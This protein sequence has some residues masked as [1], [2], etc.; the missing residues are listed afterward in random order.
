MAI[1][2]R[3]VSTINRLVVHCSMSSFG[4][5]EIIDQWHKERG[6]DKIGYH[7]VIGNGFKLKHGDY[8]PNLDG[9]IET[10]RSL[11]QVGAHVK[12]FN[13]DS[14]GV[15]LVG[16]RLFTARQTLQALPEL[17]K[18][19][20]NFLGRFLV[21]DLHS[22]LDDHKYCPGFDAAALAVIKGMVRP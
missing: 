15:C 8:D 3:D 10:G 9:K 17:I 7:Y 19:V 13:R 14:I 18:K 2:T 11:G 12:G 20:E 6:W 16:D 5:A 22:Q 21:I 4:T 1:T